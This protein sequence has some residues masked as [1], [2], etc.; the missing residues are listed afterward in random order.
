MATYIYGCNH[1]DHPR[2]ELEHGMKVE[3]IGECHLC[4]EKLHRIPQPFRHYLQPHKILQRWSEGN[5]EKKLR[6]EPR[7]YYNVTDPER[8]LPQRDYNTRR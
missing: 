4:G 1:P 2:W 6:G 3:L 5:W 7:D 8:G